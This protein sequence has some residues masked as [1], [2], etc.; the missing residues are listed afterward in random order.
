MDTAVAAVVPSPKFKWK[1]VKSK[2]FFFTSYERAL[3]SASAPTTTVRSLPRSANSFGGGGM[4]E[5]TELFPVLTLWLVLVAALVSE[6]EDE[7]PVP[8]VM[9]CVAVHEISHSPTGQFAQERLSSSGLRDILT[10]SVCVPS[11]VSL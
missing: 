11:W 9:F 1:R 5:S 6:F 10:V 8:T 4:M 3:N 7:E 2:M